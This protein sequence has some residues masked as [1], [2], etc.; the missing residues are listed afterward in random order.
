[1]N[2]QALPRRLA[3]AALA[4]VLA[5]AFVPAAALASPARAADIASGTSNTCSWTI[6]ADGALVIAPSDGANGTL[7]DYTLDDAPWL[8]HRDAIK[9][10][11]IKSGVRANGGLVGIFSRCP[12]LASVDLSGLDSTNAT[13]MANMFYSCTALKQL[14]LTGLNTVRVEVMNSMFNSCRALESINLAGFNTAN[15]SSMSGMFAGCS[16]LTTLDLSSFNT[17]RATNMSGMFEYCTMLKEV[18]LGSSFSFKGAKEEVLT[19]LPGG[20]WLSAALGYTFTAADLATQRNDTTD[21]YTKVTTPVADPDTYEVMFRL[22][23]PNS[24]EHFYTASEVERD[25]TIA[26]GW[27]DE[28]IGWTA[29]VESDTPVYRLYS[30][31]DHHYT[32]STVERDHLIDVGWTLEG[33]NAEG[34]AWYSDDQKRVP[35]YRQFNPNVDPTAP[36]NNSGSHNYTT[37]LEEHEQ[38]ISIGWRGEDIGWYGVG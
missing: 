3:T 5:L 12:N 38:L 36:F 21:S 7:D 33:D 14:D 4:F 35:L 6:D 34:I 31:T 28:G 30:G 25:A 1:M 19:E 24:G 27:N 18:R 32:T 8:A 29:P 13:S 26:A 20:N 15:V 23:N 22:Y 10:V 2:V 17:W 16:S 9:S 37:S 11:T